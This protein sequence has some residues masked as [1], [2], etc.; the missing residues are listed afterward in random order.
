MCLMSVT[1]VSQRR[2]EPVFPTEGVT[3]WKAESYRV[4]S[5]SIE[6]KP[7]SP[8]MRD[9]PVALYEPAGRIREAN[10]GPH[11][12]FLKLRSMVGEKGDLLDYPVAL[13]VFAS[14]F[15]PLGV[16]H[17]D[18]LLP[19]VLPSEKLWVAPEA[20]VEADGTLKRLDPETEGMELLLD[21]LEQQGYLG[22]EGSMFDDENEKR[23]AA[24]SRVALPPEVTLARKRPT[25]PWRDPHRLD[26][27]PVAWDK[28]RETYGALLVLDR[29]TSTRVSVLCT[30]ES[31]TSWQR[32]LLDF[33]VGE[34]RPDDRYLR[35]FLNSRLTGVSPYSPEN[36][37]EYRAGWRCSSLLE[38]MHLLL[39]LDLRGGH[40]VRECGLHDCTNYFRVG[41]QKEKTRYCSAKHTS[42]ASTRMNRGQKP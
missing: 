9:T 8:W 36:E 5:G 33:P 7:A 34:Y 3:F 4:S 21:L 40:S 42:L 38:V 13:E 31:V 41:S 17:E 12:S 20:V 23:E 6:A 15:G 26:L 11:L 28:V 27:K 29:A 2:P 18:F 37:E 1:G 32:V 30:R 35:R 19:P 24:R 22:T 10:A 25:G 16:I 39:W 14:T